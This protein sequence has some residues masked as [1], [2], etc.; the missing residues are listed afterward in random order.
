MYDTSKS[1]SLLLRGKNFDS[2]IGSIRIHHKKKGVSVSAT[3]FTLVSFI[4]EKI[5]NGLYFFKVIPGPL[6][7][8]YSCK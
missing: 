1:M 5:K 6:A 4:F 8:S 3:A 7:F 2:K